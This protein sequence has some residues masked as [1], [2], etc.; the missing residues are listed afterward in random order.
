M[1]YSFSLFD[2]IICRHRNRFQEYYVFGDAFTW[3]TYRLKPVYKTALH[4]QVFIA[5]TIIR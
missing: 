2:K 3:G 5:V 4:I 1:I